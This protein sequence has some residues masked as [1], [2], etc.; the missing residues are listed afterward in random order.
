MLIPQA[1]QFLN[2]LLTAESRYSVHSPFVYRFV[3]EVLPHAKSSIGREIETLRQ[4]ALHDEEVMEIQDWGAGYSGRH[5]SVIWKQVRE[6]AQS[7]ARKPIS[8]EFLHRL[9]KWL[10]PQVALELGSNLGFSTAYQAAGME[11]GQFISIEGAESLARKATLLWSKL[12]LEV[13]LLQGEFS[14]VLPKLL[15]E[16]Q[17][18]DYVLIDGNHQ[19]G[20]T[21][22]YFDLL[23]PKLRPNGVLII[24]DIHWSKGMQKAWK[25]IQ[26]RKEVSL[27][28]DLC[29]MGLCFFRPH[30][31][32]ENFRFRYWGMP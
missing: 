3:T 17:A 30:Q 12:D 32:K 14:S 1:F 8:G 11:G 21:L 25:E 23:F 13:N 26:A 20:A 18:F 24:D 7:S 19:Y 6:V 31:A 16:Q 2:H 5:Q 22:A 28:I 4:D 10:Q 9:V 15:Q 29:F 27:T